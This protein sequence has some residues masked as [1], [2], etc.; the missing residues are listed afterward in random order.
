MRILHIS[1]PKSWRGGEQQVA[2][3]YE[4]LHRLGAEQ[5]L[6]CPEDSELK[7]YAEQQNFN[8][9]TFKKSFSVNPFTAYK[10]KQICRTEKIDLIHAHDSHAHGFAWLAALLFGNKTPI[11]VSRRLAFP[12]KKSFTTRA[13]YN[14]P[15]VAKILCVSESVRRAVAP[16]LQ[17]ENKLTI[18]P[19]GIDNQRFKKEKTGKLHAL[20]GIPFNKILI[21]NTAA[22]TKN[23]D[24][25]TFLRTAK[26]LLDDGVNAH[27]FIIGRD[28][29]EG[30]ALRK[31]AADMKMEKE[32]TFTGFRRDL[33]DLLPEFDIFLFTSKKEGFGSSILDAMAAG[34]PVV[35]TQAGGTADFLREGTNA[36]SAPPGAANSLAKKVK[37]LIDLPKM[38]DRMRKAGRATARKYGKEK[39]AEKT[40]KLYT[41]ILCIK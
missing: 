3:L 39:T 5:I 31:Y 40:H 25:L 29:G 17:D 24:W 1:T 41:E 20:F 4:E 18:I 10:I 22:L 38:R 34:V 8:L 16:T 11:V 9:R 19:D 6:F 30:E 32:V 27:F 7:K 21:G 35:T 28:E 15:T 37:K 13:K 2:W 12:L 33:A 14:A 26:I 23:K 36:L